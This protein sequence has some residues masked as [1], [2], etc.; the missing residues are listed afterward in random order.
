[1]SQFYWADTFSGGGLL[2][3][4]EF[5]VC[6]FVAACSI[7]HWGCNKLLQALCIVLMIITVIITWEMCVIYV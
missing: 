7:R 4:L 1:M 2:S 6:P 5:R 3:V